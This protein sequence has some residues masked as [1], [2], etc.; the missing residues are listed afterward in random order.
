MS[1]SPNPERS[2]IASMTCNDAIILGLAPITGK[3]LFS[4]GALG[5]MH[6]KQGVRPGIMVVTSPLSPSTPPWMRGMSS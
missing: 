1:N 3:G 6:L 4:L 2:L 5:K